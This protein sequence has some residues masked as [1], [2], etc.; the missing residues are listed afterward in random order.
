MLS[1]NIVTHKVIVKNPDW[2]WITK[3][4]LTKEM[5]AD[6]KIAKNDRKVWD[7]IWLTDI[8]WKRIRELDPIKF[9]EFEE[10]KTDSSMNE[11]V[12]IC[13][14]WNRHPMHMAG[15]CECSKEYDCLAI[16]FMPR[17]KELWFTINY[18]S[19]I[20]KSM[21]LAYKQKNLR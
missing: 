10:V 6:Y 3:Y 4:P 2:K 20:T 16:M 17:L 9:E 11:K 14:F 13:A 21:Q 18:P 19:E 1:T 8:D 12:W 7:T 15:D 5:Y